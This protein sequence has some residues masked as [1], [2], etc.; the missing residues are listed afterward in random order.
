MQVDE[1]RG[2]RH[3]EWSRPMCR[4]VR[5]QA[6][7]ADPH[8]I[9]R[10]TSQ[11]VGSCRGGLGPSGVAELHF[12]TIPS[13]GLTGVEATMRPRNRSTMVRLDELVTD[14][15]SFIKIRVEGHELSVLE[16]AISL[17]QPGKPTA[18]TR[19]ALTGSCLGPT[20]LTKLST[21]ANPGPRQP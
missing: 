12:P 3:G 8:R 5:P 17:L 18:K 16:G 2:R 4:D 14:R 6:L 9:G 7:G 21:L 1:P 13:T 19:G 11:H 20:T 10:A 15:V